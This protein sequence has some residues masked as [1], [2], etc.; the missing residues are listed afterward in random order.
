MVSLSQ[1]FPARCEVFLNLRQV[2]RQL[3]RALNFD[4]SGSS[5]VSFTL[6]APL[7]VSL[8]V[9]VA[10]VVVLVADKAVITSAATVGARSASASDASLT[11]G[12][13]K[14]RQVLSSRAGIANSAQIS[15]RRELI[16]G[17][18]YVRM[19]VSGE[20]RIPWLNQRIHI[21]STSRALDERSL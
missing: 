13:V 17:V 3:N 5:V 2:R 6:V 9:A 19:T 15:I 11:T 4:D 12:V 1:Y 10:Q 8:F 7:L 16:S 18:S 21:S 20:V 14:A